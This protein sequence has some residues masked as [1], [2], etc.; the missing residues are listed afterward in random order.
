[1]TMLFCADVLA[2]RRNQTTPCFILDMYFP[3][4]PVP[5]YRGLPEP[6]PGHIIVK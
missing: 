4:L 5:I 2:A 1:M 6:S 3:A